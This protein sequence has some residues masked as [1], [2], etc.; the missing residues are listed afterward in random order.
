[1]KAYVAPFAL[2][3]VLALSA[4][5]SPP[6]TRP[7]VSDRELSPR[8]ISPG[9]RI[10]VAFNLEMKEPDAVK[11]VFIRG[12]PKNTMLAAARIIAIADQRLWPHP[13]L[14]LAD[15]R[16]FMAGLR[17]P[18]FRSNPSETL[19]RMPGIGDQA[20]PKRRRC[21]TQ[22]SGRSRNRC[23]RLAALAPELGHDR[24]LC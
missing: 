9:Q 7:I 20:N 11:R 23:R 2:T 3:I 6:E 10:A 18:V 22:G 14:S 4:C 12:L 21:S 8:E 24:S 16:L 17:R 13:P 5:A 19:H 1:M 15:N